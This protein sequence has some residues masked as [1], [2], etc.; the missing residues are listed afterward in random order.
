MGSTIVGQDQRAGE[1]CA[2]YPQHVVV[3][4]YDGSPSSRAA[5]AHGGRWVGRGGRLIVVRALP[6]I[7]RRPRNGPDDRPG[8]YADAVTSLL[9]AV[10]TELP[11]TVTH[12]I[13]V[14]AGS[15][16]KALVQTAERHRASEV[17]LGAGPGRMPTEKNGTADA[18]RT[19]TTIPVVIVGASARRTPPRRDAF[20]I[21]GGDRRRRAGLRWL[22]AFIKEYPVE[23]PSH[24]RSTGSGR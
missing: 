18:V 14:V 4:G 13:R 16:A 6:A 9:A 21:G 17:V 23:K 20:M 12:E 11:R 10:G 7:R 2:G 22:R 15:P 3:V 1:P 8:R 19:R 5:L 24:G